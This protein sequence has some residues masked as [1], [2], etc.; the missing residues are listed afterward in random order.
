MDQ[1]ATTTPT[2]PARSFGAPAAAP[3]FPSARADRA[4]LAPYHAVHPSFRGPTWLK[5]R[6]GS[7]GVAG[8]WGVSTA[9]AVAAVLRKPE[10][11]EDSKEMEMHVSETPF[12][13]VVLT[14]P[15]LLSLFYFSYLNKPSSCTSAVRCRNSQRAQAYSEWCSDAH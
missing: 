2:D 6:R 13:Y 14:L 15:T 5:L 8:G 7:V 1:A 12:H 11:N 3:P 4:L 9:A 10:E